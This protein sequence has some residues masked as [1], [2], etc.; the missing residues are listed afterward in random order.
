MEQI[1]QKY[2]QY[3]YK[4]LMSL[5]HDT[6]VAEELTQ[7]TFYQAIKSLP[8]YD[9]RSKLSTWLVG[10]A[11]NQYLVYLRKNPKH[12]NVEDQAMEPA[13]YRTPEAETLQQLSRV[14]VLKLLHN[15][16]EPYREVLY[17]RMFEDLSF[18]DI[19]EIM[20]KSENWARVNFYRG[21]EKLKTL[22]LKEH[23]Q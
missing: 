20:D 18:R 14:Q 7:E 17:L 15:C 5:C 16:Q 8:K 13:D 6:F 19:G 1:Y 12:E 3:V 11:R 9:E 4:Y 2:A 10:I 22:Y 21:K 23:N